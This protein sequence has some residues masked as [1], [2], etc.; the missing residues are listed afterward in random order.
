VTDILTFRKR[1]GEIKGDILANGH[2][3]TRGMI[4]QHGSYMPQESLFLP[5]QTAEEALTFQAKMKMR[6]SVG[7]GNVKAVD[8]RSMS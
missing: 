3:V 2:A 4:A 5:I 7:G 6:R 1:L 8:E